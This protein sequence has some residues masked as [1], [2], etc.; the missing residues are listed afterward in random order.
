MPTSPSIH[1]CLPLTHNSANNN[2]TD[3]KMKLDKKS[4]KR[5]LHRSNS[6]FRKH[7]QWLYNKRRYTFSCSQESKIIFK[8]RR[9][10]ASIAWP[11]GGDRTDPLNLKSL[12]DEEEQLNSPKRM[13][14]R[15]TQVQVVIPQDIH[16]PLNLNSA[17]VIVPKEQRR[18][19]PRKRRRHRK[20]RREE[21]S[22]EELSDQD[23]SHHRIIKR[24]IC[25]TLHKFRTERFCYGNHITSF[26]SWNFDG[27]SGDPRIRFFNIDFFRGK[28]ILD[29]GCNTGKLTL[30]IANHFYPQKITG[31]DIDKKLLNIAERQMRN[32]QSFTDIPKSMP[33]LYGP[34]AKVLHMKKETNVV[35][36]EANYV[37]ACEDYLET[38]KP[39]YDTILCLRVTKWIHLNFGDEGLKLT[40]KRIYAQLRFGGRL[41]LEPQPWFTYSASKRITP[42]IYKTYC[43]LK[44]RPETFCDFLLSSEVGFSSCEVIGRITN[45]AKVFL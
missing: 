12:E 15:P 17:E 45:Y 41:I 22:T 37:P 5:H 20:S 32:V 39:E 11:F 38:Q 29:I 27:N 25:S 10:V 26:N 3:I 19:K 7:S 2:C 18:L 21:D 43:S 4:L 31:I 9:R 40:F 36:L 44:M 42:S 30:L 8:K 28:N 13:S 34:L 23:I 33:L 24:K 14:P 35:F 1:Q 6:F 16:D